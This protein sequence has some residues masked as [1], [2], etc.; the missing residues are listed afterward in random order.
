MKKEIIILLF[1]F[2]IPSIIAIETSLSKDSYNP[3]ELFQ[4][5]ITGNFISLTSEN[6]LIY[7]STAV[8]STPVISDLTKQGDTYYFYAIL[9]NQQGNFSLKIED[10]QYMEAGKIKTQTITKDFIIKQTNDS[11]LSINPGFIVTSEDFTIKVKALNNN[12]EISAILEST[13]ETKDFSLIEETEKTITFLIQTQ[14]TKTTNLKINDYNV[15]VFI[16]GK[17]Q[18]PSNESNQSEINQSNGNNETPKINIEN[19]TQEQIAVM[20]CID[21][22]KGCLTGEKCEGETVASLDGPCCVGTCVEKKQS[23]YT[24]IIGL[25][26]IILILILVWFFYFKAKKRQKPKS[27]EDI[28][29]DKSQRFEDRMQGSSVT[30]GISSS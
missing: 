20:D 7:G 1:L 2:L 28:L 5:E 9:P 29:R 14:E 13:S 21:I 16:L 24:W 18:I 6:I 3:Q 11:A 30:G 17:T 19:K 8:H 23:S 10:S 26:I 12:Q 22:G 4:A 15:P 25:G 27:T